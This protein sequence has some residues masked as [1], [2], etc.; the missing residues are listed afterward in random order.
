[1]DTKFSVALHILTM[2]SESRDILSSQSLAIS[3][4]TNASYVR[5]VISLLKKHHLIVSHQGKIGYQLMKKP[6][7]LTLLEIYFATQEIEHV[8]LFQVHQNANQ[9]CPV[10]RYIDKAVSPIFSE[11]EGQ[12][13]LLLGTRTLGDVIKNLYKEAE[14]NTDK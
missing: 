3:I 9:A 5:K 4:G 7:E 1:M 12:M 6:S 14:K 10:G 8:N 11:L 13:E 2:I